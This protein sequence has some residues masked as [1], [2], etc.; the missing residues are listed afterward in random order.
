MDFAFNE[1]QTDIQAL[2]DT[3]FKDLS[4][5]DLLAKVESQPQRVDLSLWAALQEAGLDV[6]A[7]SED[8]GGAGLSFLEACLVIEKLGRYTAPVPLIVHTLAT[9]S[10]AE[11]DQAA[12]LERLQ[13]TGA[14]VT[15]TTG[16]AQN[17]LRLENG[18]V[19]GTVSNVPYV[20]GAQGLV[21][22]VLAPIPALVLIDP[23]DTGIEWQNQTSTALEPQGYGILTHVPAIVI[24]SE[25]AVKVLHLRELAANA[26]AQLGV[27]EAAM[28]LARGH[29][30][31]RE[32][33]GVKIGSFQAVSH[34]LADCWIDAMNLRTM[35]LTAASR[36][37]RTVDTDTAL[38]V[39]V[40]HSW[41]C[42]AGHRVLASCQHVCGGLG[43]DKDYPMWRFAVWSR[44]YEIMM[45]GNEFALE[46]LGKAI[47][48]SPTSAML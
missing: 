34:R 4:S 25:E 22:P 32:Q 26:M 20:Q 30:C 46:Q 5:P 33:F 2:A 40:A 48:S 38:D 36:L 12:Q 15:A 19:S 3:L 45:G 8:L 28:A 39:Y 16:R 31:E 37:T 47:T 41:A 10:L 18:L 6:V 11:S 13:T 7:L 42:E 27:V 23:R 17:T 44:H 43:H 21:V 9:L 24:G 29:V 1:I 35:A 14:W